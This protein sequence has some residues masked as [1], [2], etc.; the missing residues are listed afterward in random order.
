MKVASIWTPVNAC[1]ADYRI[2]NVF[3]FSSAVALRLSWQL[4]QYPRFS[5]YNSRHGWGFIDSLVVFSHRLINWLLFWIFIFM[6]SIPLKLLSSQLLDSSLKLVILLAVL[7]RYNLFDKLFLIGNQLPEHQQ[8]VSPL[9]IL[10]SA[11]SPR[12]LL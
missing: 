6:N 2:I 1:L 11:C 3:N 4:R 9:I 10:E 12:E 8:A 7:I 5:F